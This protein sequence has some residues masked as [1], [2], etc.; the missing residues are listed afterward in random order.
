MK[1]EFD[2]KKAKKGA[3]V[4]KKTAKLVTSIRFDLDIVEWAVQEAA[5]ERLPYGTFINRKLRELKEQQSFSPWPHMAM[6]AALKKRLETI[7]KDNEEAK[8][9]IIQ[10]EK[11]LL[12]VEKAS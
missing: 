9:K 3:L 12:K 4:D 6:K 8:K 10:L 7:Q 11:R 2:F 5:K 1:K